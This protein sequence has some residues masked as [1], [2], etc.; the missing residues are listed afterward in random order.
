MDGSSAP[1]VELVGTPIL[2]TLPEPETR[3]R[4][5]LIPLLSRGISRIC[6]T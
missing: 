1:R 6:R 3:Q 5:R 2:L 4:I